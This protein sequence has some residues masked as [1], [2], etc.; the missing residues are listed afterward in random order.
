MTLFRPKNSYCVNLTH[1]PI[2]TVSSVWSRGFSASMQDERCLCFTCPGAVIVTTPQDVAL[3]D[4]RRGA[5]MFRDL[6][7]PVL[8]VVQ[9]MSHHVCPQCGHTSHPFGRDG[10][11]R[12]A[13]EMNLE[14][15]GDVPLHLDVREGA[16]RGCPVLA[17][18]PHSPLSSAY[19]A[20]ASR[21]LEKLSHHQSPHDEHS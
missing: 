13:S 17:T 18:Q 3:A 6:H 4:A 8:G 12:L 16:D 21:L 19:L 5:Q 1:K 20:I 14:L 7:T 15:L 10:A 9:N 11:A 2:C